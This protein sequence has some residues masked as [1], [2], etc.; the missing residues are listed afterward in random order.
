MANPTSLTLVPRAGEFGR[1]ELPLVPHEITLMSAEDAAALD[2]IVS[3][4]LFQA[5]RRAA[6]GDDPAVFAWGTSQIVDAFCEVVEPNDASLTDLDE[7]YPLADTDFDHD[8]LVILAM[9]ETHRLHP[10]SRVRIVAE[11]VRHAAKCGC[12]L[13]VTTQDPYVLE[14]V[15]VFAARNCV[16]DRLRT[17]WVTGGAP[18]NLHYA[19][20]DVTD[21]IERVY[22]SLAAP[23]QYLEDLIYDDYESDDDLVRLA[24]NYAHDN[25]DPRRIETDVRRLTGHTL[26]LSARTTESIEQNDRE[27]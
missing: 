17:L 11:F 6:R 18:G 10:A 25:D 3:T 12:T 16:A 4:A 20:E 1:V 21:D 8:D 15:E 7:G 26:A 13:V 2:T 14:T 24:Y 22:A 19:V 9:P 5:M 23:L 27:Q